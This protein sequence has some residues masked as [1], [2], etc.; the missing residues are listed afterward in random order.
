[1]TLRFATLSG[2]LIL[3]A[4]ADTTP[5]PV[6]ESSR[7]PDG[8]VVTQSRIA[9]QVGIRVLEQGGNAVD[10]AVATAF[11]LAVVE[12][13]NSGLGGRTQI[14]LRTAVGDIHAIDAT[15]QVPRSYPVDSVPPASASSGYGM[16]GIPGTVAGLTKALEE[17]GSWPLERVMEPAIELAEQGFN[18][19]GGQARSIGGVAEHLAKFEGSSRHFLKEDGS[20][21]EEGELF[22]QP[23]LGNTLRQIAQG[24]ADA[25]YK[26]AIARRIAEDHAANG[27]FVTLEDLADYRT[28]HLG[29]EPGEV[30]VVEA[31]Q[32][33]AVGLVCAV[34]PVHHLVG[35]LVAQGIVEL[36][37]KLGRNRHLRRMAP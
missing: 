32:V 24:G 28:V 19:P 9:S 4:C 30:E 34:E 36:L 37:G 2:F 3:T 15:T 6:G 5:P 13:T 29:L 21:Y 14:L 31:I 11:A 20:A 18:L 33:G 25:F 26:G 1:M 27:G 16:V 10:A 12:P 23:D 17:H 7:S 35:D 22:V 8:A